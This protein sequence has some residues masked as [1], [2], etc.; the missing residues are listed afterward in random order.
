MTQVNQSGE[1]YGTYFEHS[2]QNIVITKVDLVTPGQSNKPKWASFNLILFV[3]DVVSRSNVSRNIQP[4][5][6]TRRITN[7]SSGNTK[8][9][10]TMIVY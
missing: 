9:W 1:A 2:T 6:E 8:N 10:K 4:L 5:E 3:K 7:M